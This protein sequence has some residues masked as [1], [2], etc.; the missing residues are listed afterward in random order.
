MIDLHLHTQH[1]QMV[2]LNQVILASAQEARDLVIYL[3]QIPRL[4]R[5]AYK[6]LS[7]KLHSLFYWQNRQDANFCCAWGTPIKY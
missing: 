5:I 3:I 1:L 2:Q 7:V 6:S 4:H